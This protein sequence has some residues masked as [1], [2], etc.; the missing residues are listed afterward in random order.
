MKKIIKYLSTTRNYGIV[1]RHPSKLVDSSARIYAAGRP[2]L[3]DESTLQKYINSPLEIFCDADFAGDVTRRSTSGNISFFYGGPLRWLAQLQKLYALST[4]ESEIYSAVE[5]VKDAAHLKLLLHSLRVRPDEPVPVH[6]D[7]SACRIMTTQSLKSFNRARHYTTRLGFLQDNHGDTFE[8]IPCDTTD[9][10]A[11]MF[12][13]SLPADSF[14]K[15]R[16]M[17]VHDVTRLK[18]A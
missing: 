5:A 11:D 6:E 16:D 3:K 4:A 14:V 17:V 9:M 7:N 12:T 15:F 10:I 1:Y 18:G 8:F 13:K 2:P